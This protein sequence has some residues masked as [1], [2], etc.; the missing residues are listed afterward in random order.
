[1]RVARIGRIHDELGGLV[2]VVAAAQ[3]ELVKLVARRACHGQHLRIRTCGRPVSPRHGLDIIFE[4]RSVIRRLEE[5]DFVGVAQAQV[6]LIGDGIDLVGN[7]GR[8]LRVLAGDRAHRFI[9]VLVLPANAGIQFPLRIDVVTEPYILL[10]AL[11]GQVDIVKHGGIVTQCKVGCR[12]VSSCRICQHTVRQNLRIYF[13]LG[14]TVGTTG[15]AIE[16]RPQPGAGQGENVAASRAI[17]G[18]LVTVGT[19]SQQFIVTGVDLELALLPK[20]E[21]QVSRVQPQIGT[22]HAH[23]CCVLA[24]VTVTGTHIKVNDGTGAFLL[25]TVVFAGLVGVAADVSDANLNRAGGL[26]Q[27]CGGH[28]FIRVGD[29]HGR[30]R[31]QRAVY[32]NYHRTGCKTSMVHVHNILPIQFKR[33]ALELGAGRAIRS[34]YQHMA[35]QAGT[36]SKL[37]P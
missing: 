14:K 36:R 12:L 21:R 5:F 26:G 33:L 35:V 4:Y 13:C 25:Q 17:V 3:T 7:R 28:F 9:A 31:K 18:C 11:G 19:I 32:S 15:C 27:L 16:L 22:R 24:V 10:A 8:D 20:L 29:G 2:D 37:G 23:A 34:M 30:H 1:M 6:V